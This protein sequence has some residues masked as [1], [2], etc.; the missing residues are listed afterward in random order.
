MISLPMKSE[1]LMNMKL[2][3]GVVKGNQVVD[4]CKYHIESINIDDATTSKSNVLTIGE[5]NLSTGT[6]KRVTF[7]V[8]NLHF[9]PVNIYCFLNMELR[10]FPQTGIVLFLCLRRR[11]LIIHNICIMDPRK[12]K[13]NIEI[14]FDFS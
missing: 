3:L 6:L 11:E 2:L 14:K 8:C 1:I 10:F 12:C 7:H 4:A 13:K 9:I 5:F